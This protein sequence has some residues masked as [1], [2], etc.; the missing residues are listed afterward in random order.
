ML[1]QNTIVSY[2]L[3][4]LTTSL[5]IISEQVLNSLSLRQQLISSQLDG[6]L[7]KLVVHAQALDDAHLAAA[8]CDGEREDEALGDSILRPVGQ[9]AC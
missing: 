6:L 7:G 5:P 4:D 3:Y 1:S 8:G 9:D 2:L